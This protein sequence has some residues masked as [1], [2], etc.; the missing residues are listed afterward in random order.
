MDMRA[1]QELARA[2]NETVRIHEASWD[3]EKKTYT[4]DWHQAAQLGCAD[5]DLVMLV[6]AMAAGGYCEYSDWADKFLPRLRT[7]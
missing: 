7:V 5:Q 3:P 4:M 1:K 2:Y 6:Y